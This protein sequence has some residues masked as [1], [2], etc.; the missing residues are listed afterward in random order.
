MVVVYKSK[1]G[2]TKQYAEWIAKAL[3][4]PIFENAEITPQELAEHDI[5]IYGGGLYA[6]GIDGIKLV[7]KNQCKA[8][9]V[10]TVGVADPA[11]TDYAE[12]LNRAFTPAQLAATKIFHLR[13]GID[14]SRLSLPHR[15]M[16][17]MMK[18]IIEKKPP[19]KRGSDDMG[20][21][22]TYGKNVD[23]SSEKTIA[24]L[25]EHVRGIMEGK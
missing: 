9:V 22:E 7:T 12:I 13:G 16:M 24:P 11:V 25:V 8:L 20:V 21:L 23:F 2:K 10:F 3:G 15:A 17:A 5:V 6:G 14:Y 19:E 4:A 1:Y 18:R